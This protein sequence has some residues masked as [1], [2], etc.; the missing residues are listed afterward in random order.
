MFLK[1][2][3]ERALRGPAKTGSGFKDALERVR[4]GRV[5]KQ[6]D[7]ELI[8]Q[9]L[10]WF[11]LSDPAERRKISSPLHTIL[12]F[13]QTAEDET[14]RGT[15]RY[16][17]VPEL[18]R[19]YREAR[20]ALGAGDTDPELA[21]DLAYLCKILSLYG[22]E[23]GID[24]IID[25]ARDPLLAN[26]YLWSVMFEIIA[27][28]KHPW[29]FMLLQD[30]RDP[31]PVGHARIG[32]LDF[33][34]TVCREENRQDHPFRTEEG[35]RVLRDILTSQDADEFSYA[36]SAAAALP[37]LDAGLGSELLPIALNHP[38][39]D[40]RL[41][42]AWAAVR[43][44]YPDQGL[45]ALEKACE[46]PRTARRA[47]EYLQELGFEDRI[48]L[49][50]HNEDFQAAAEFCAWLAHPM[51]YGSPPDDVELVDSRELYWP[52]T[53]DERQLWIF[54]YNYHSDP[55]ASG[56]GMVGSITFA[57]FGEATED[58]SPEEVYGL[59]CAWELEANEDPR[60]PAERTPEAGLAI[61]REHNSWKI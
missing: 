58:L 24:V 29:R 47:C 37:F 11:P 40:V 28:S 35:L 56:F 20:G 9:C 5:E 4:A 27:D 45:P 60:A 59:H 33:A 12:T 53:N 10:K 18:A 2:K 1:S 43:A 52:P 25:A 16:H 13:F 17:G 8:V 32:Y 48:P 50:A 6:S 51:E 15:F 38:S 7:A 46:D 19:I 26:G 3:I 54:R 55:D 36:Q 14:V 42:A 39:A 34:N 44:G 41:E 23:P 61:L 57:L 21:G 31:L 49:V 22:A 30:L